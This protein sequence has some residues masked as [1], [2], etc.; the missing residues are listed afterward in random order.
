MQ[1][2]Q[3]YNKY[4]K[5]QNILYNYYIHEYITIVFNIIQDISIILLFLMYYY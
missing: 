4:I 5:Y 3:Y 2:I 1:N